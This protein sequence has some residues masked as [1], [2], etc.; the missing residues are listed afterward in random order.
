MDTDG[1]G[2]A[3]GVSI[4]ASSLPEA[5]IYVCLLAITFFVDQ[6][7]HKQV[8]PGRCSASVWQHISGPHI[9][10]GLYGD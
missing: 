1:A 7:D 5:E 9:I 10:R 8:L 2:A 3:P 4:T 6:K